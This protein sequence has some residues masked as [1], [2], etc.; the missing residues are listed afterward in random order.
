MSHVSQKKTMSHVNNE[1]LLNLFFEILFYE[2]INTTTYN[3]FELF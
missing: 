1:V 2:L 3:Q